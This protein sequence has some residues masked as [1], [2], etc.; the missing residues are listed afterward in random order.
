M[1]TFL[2][3]TA[4]NAVIAGSAA[5]YPC[6]EVKYSELPNAEGR[7]LICIVA[8]V[9][10]PKNYHYL[11]ISFHNDIRDFTRSLQRLDHIVYSCFFLACS[12]ADSRAVIADI[13]QE[14]PELVLLDPE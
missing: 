3:Q 6:W 9:S 11:T 13:R 2:N 4:T 8:Y 5:S 12:A 14:H 1:K 7:D 10:L